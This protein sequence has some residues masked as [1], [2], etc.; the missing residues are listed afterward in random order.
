MTRN[1]LNL[2][3]VFPPCIVTAKLNLWHLLKKSNLGNTIWWPYWKFCS[4]TLLI[5]TLDLHNITIK[6][7]LQD[8]KLH[9]PKFIIFSF[10]HA[11]S[12]LE[13][14]PISQKINFYQEVIIGFG[15]QIITIPR[16]M[17]KYY[18]LFC[19]LINLTRMYFL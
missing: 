12:H 13:F 4:I 11:G 19:M 8:H 6:V 17:R 9:F 2:V 15:G 14:I 16:Y 7:N 5:Y 10:S 3:S 18:Y 1:P